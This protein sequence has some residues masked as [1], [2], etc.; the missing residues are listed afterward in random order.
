MLHFTQIAN[1]PSLH[2]NTRH[3]LKSIDIQNENL[4]QEICN[5]VFTLIQQSLV[6]IFSVLLK[7]TLL[8][9]HL[10]LTTRDLV[11]THISELC[12]CKSQ[13]KSVNHSK[14][15]I[16]FDK[17]GYFSLSVYEIVCLK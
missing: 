10:S 7:N 9:N 14:S 5:L 8:C 11:K 15:K 13:K 1:S 6:V 16:P 2:L 17:L 4:N 3:T 12:K